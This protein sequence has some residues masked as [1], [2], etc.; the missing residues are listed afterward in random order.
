MDDQQE[1]RRRQHRIRSMINFCQGIAVTLFIFASLVAICLTVLYHGRIVPLINYAIVF[2][3]GS[4]HT[5][6]F[7][8]HWPADKSNGLGSTSSVNELFVCPL[9]SIRVEDPKKSGETIKLKAVSDFEQHLHLLQPYFQS[10]LEKAMDKIP[11]DRHKFSP[12]FLGATAGM[13]LSRL[14]NATRA[15]QLLERIREVFS[16]YPFQ[17]VTARQVTFVN[18]DVIRST[19]SLIEGYVD[20]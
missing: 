7:V 11:S 1:F 3:A 19:C 10:C 4:S 14:Q 8:Y 12:I 5:E 20:T 13:R 17:F 6:M 2:D 15:S 16:N 18:I 9:S